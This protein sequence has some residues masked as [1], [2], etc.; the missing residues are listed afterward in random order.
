MINR[1]KRS[2]EHFNWY[3]LAREATWVLKAHFSAPQL[4]NLNETVLSLEPEGPPKGNV[5]LSYVNEA[6]FL[7]PG[8]PVPHSHTNYW[9]A[10]QIARTFLDLG[11]YVDVIS[12]Y[13]TTF[14]PKKDY[15]F[16]TGLRVN[17]ERISPLL[18]RDCVKILHIDAAH[19]LFHNSAELSRFFAL[20]QRRGITL[21]R[22]RL[23]QP[24]LAIE[25]ADCATMLG[26][27][28]TAS[29]YRYANKPTYPIPI[30]T[31]FLYP[32]P[33]GKDFSGCRRRFLWFGNDGFVH[34]G[35]D[36]VLEAFTELRG[37]DLTV[38]GPIQ[39]E[40]D[41]EHA[42]YKELYQTPNIHTVGWVDIASSEFLEIVNN[43]IGLIYPSCSEGQCGAVVTCLHAGLIPIISYQSGVDVH[44][45][46][47][48]LKTCSIEELKDSIKNTSNLPIDTLRS[49]ARSAWDFARANHTRERFAQ[50][51]RKAIANILGE[52]PSPADASGAC[53]RNLIPPRLSTEALVSRHSKPLTE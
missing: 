39:Q 10:L 42:Y 19:W 49:M 44:D 53:L 38:C 14:I 7:A 41:F 16:F 3:R 20:Q 27:D 51:Y 52:T 35:L 15:S 48:I 24:N 28:F 47:V 50:E 34:K 6:F 22:L 1:I 37:Y 5:L 21:T 18:N 13:N 40:K 23:S 43:S 31:P 2:L 17:M 8:E 32:P 33:D 4:A 45:F 9:E 12:R 26:N 11:Y 25:H 30:S 36:L 29:T 46:G